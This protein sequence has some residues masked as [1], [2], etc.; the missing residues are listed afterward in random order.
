MNSNQTVWVV[1]VETSLFGSFTTRV[2]GVFT[3]EQRAEQE[4]DEVNSEGDP[5]TFAFVHE[6][7]LN[8]ES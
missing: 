5:N 1:L 4:A 8:T 6:T 2:Q 3:S 7:L